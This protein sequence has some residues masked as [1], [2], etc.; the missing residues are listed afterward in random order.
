LFVKY[1]SA[2]IERRC[3]AGRAWMSGSWPF[4]W[5]SVLSDMMAGWLKVVDCPLWLISI[6]EIGGYDDV[7]RAI[8]DSR[9]DKITDE[10]ARHMK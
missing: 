9:L 3:G 8:D 4:S 2:G 10:H 6:A 7:M 1:P 5:F